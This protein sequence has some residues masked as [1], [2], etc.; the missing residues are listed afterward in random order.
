MVVAALALTW[1]VDEAK[2]TLLGGIVAFLPN[3]YFAWAAGRGGRGLDG[4]H[5]A[6]VEGGKFLGRWLV[7]MG[8]MVALLVIALGVLRAGSLGFFIGL[9]AAL[10]APLAAPLVSRKDV[11]TSGRQP[12]D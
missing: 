11:A 2:S 7:K 9:V 3:A 4:E 8:L 10:M 1:S 6:V 5:G 12:R